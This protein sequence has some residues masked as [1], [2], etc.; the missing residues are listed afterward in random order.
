LYTSGIAGQIFFDALKEQGILLA[1]RCRVCRQVYLPARA[2]CERCLSALTEQVK[3]KPTGRLV[4]FTMNY[5][6]RDRRRLRRPQA[7]ALTQLDGTTTVLLHYLLEVTDPRQVH[8]GAK[9]ELIIKPKRQRQ[10]S[11]LDLQGFRLVESPN[12]RVATQSGKKK[13]ARAR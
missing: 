1:T 10:G 3:I 4:S 8:C 6:D 13:S 9:V 12:K 7:L 11:I 5:I 2:F